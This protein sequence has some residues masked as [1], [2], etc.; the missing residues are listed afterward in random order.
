[1][2]N[3]YLDP[4]TQLTLIIPKFITCCAYVYYIINCNLSVYIKNERMR[5]IDVRKRT[6][7]M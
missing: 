2:V 6:K 5:D 1:L 4:G 3:E 7:I